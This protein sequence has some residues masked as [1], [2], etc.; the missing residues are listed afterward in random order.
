MK[1]SRILVPIDGSETSWVA[2]DKAIDLAREHNA[3]LRVIEVVDLG[4]VFRAT[5]TAQSLVDIQTAIIR[6]CERDLARAV[7]LAQKAGVTAETALINASER[8]IS[9]EI[10]EE[11]ERWHADLI[12][13]G[14]HGRH[15]LERFFLGSVA[16][17]V[18]R[19]A[20]VPVLLIRSA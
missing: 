7:E 18:A 12:M 1:F 17:G 4:P 6:D 10:V 16:E 3:R 19:A 15:G 8:H 14:T 13:M 20:T 5:I 11:A 2:L 9:T